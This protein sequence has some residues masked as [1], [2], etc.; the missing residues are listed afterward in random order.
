MRHKSYT[1]LFHRREDLAMSV[2][3]TTLVVSLYLA[4]A[5]AYMKVSV[6]CTLLLVTLRLGMP[7]F[8]L[9]QLVVALKDVEDAAALQ[10]CTAPYAGLANIAL[11]CSG[12]Q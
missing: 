11:Y 9:D 3:Q 2:E 1:H 5:W 4:R 12:C 8:Q 7:L 10:S 6:S